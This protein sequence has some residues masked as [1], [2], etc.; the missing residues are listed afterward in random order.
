VHAPAHLLDVVASVGPDL[1]AAGTIGT[2]DVVPAADLR[3][4]VNLGGQ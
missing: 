3:V 2:L 4:E 1:R